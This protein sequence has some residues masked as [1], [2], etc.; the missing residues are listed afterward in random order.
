MILRISSPC[1]EHNVKRQHICFLVMECDFRNLKIVCVFACV[2]VYVCVFA[3]V[4][5]GVCGWVCVRTC[6]VSN[7]PIVLF[8]F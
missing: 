8:L 7:H 3:C 4:C 5:V 6:P 1:I 2:H